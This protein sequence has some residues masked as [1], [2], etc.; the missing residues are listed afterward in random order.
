MKKAII[1]G[2]SSGIGRSLAHVLNKN[3]YELGLAA[4]RLDLLTSLQKELATKTFV[5][6]I[7]VTHYQEAIIHVESLIQEMG[8]VDLFIIN[9]G[10]CFNNRNLDWKKET[11]TVDVNVGGFLSM[12]EAAMKHF[13]HKGKGH[14]VGISS[15]SALRGESSSPAYCASK[16]FVSNYLEG[17]RKRMF[18]E[19]KEIFITDIKPGWVDTDMAKGEETFWMATPEEAAQNI[20][21]TIVSKKAHAYVTPRWRLMAWLLKLAPNW[22]YDRFL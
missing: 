16:A 5:R 13:L 10:I 11:L 6:Q 1:I 18:Q 22:M 2:A 12:T 3:G 17:L 7:D 20:Y 21:E 14:L 15:I 8:G 9:A 4:R 19:K